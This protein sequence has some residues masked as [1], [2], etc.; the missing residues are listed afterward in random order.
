[1]PHINP[2]ICVMVISNSAIIAGHGLSEISAKDQARQRLSPFLTAR[3]E[4]RPAR[5]STFVILVKDISSSRRLFQFP[6]LI[7]STMLKSSTL[8]HDG[9]SPTEIFSPGYSVIKRFFRLNILDVL[10]K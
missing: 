4:R 10:S 9:V 8:L 7:S 5:L 3:L 2:I 6:G 1:M